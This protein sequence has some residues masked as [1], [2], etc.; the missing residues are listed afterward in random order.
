TVAQP[1]ADARTTR[2][3]ID[4]VCGLCHVRFAGPLRLRVGRWA[5][6]GVHEAPRCSTRGRW[7]WPGVPRRTASGERARMPL[8]I[9]RGERA[10]V[11]PDALAGLLA[12]PLPD[13]FATEVVAVPAKGVERWLTQRLSG[14]LGV[15]AAPGG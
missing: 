3:N 11:L 12:D 15:S 2:P 6:N 13:P 14:V 5:Y 1:P 10:D 4:R 7:W 9:H 8:H